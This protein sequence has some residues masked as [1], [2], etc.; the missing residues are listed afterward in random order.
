M[1]VPG[2]FALFATHA[3]MSQM[4]VTGLGAGIAILAAMI[5]TDIE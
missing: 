1:S 2:T 5:R 3:V 4:G